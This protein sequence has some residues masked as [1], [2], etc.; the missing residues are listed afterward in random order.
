MK[1]LLV[2]MLLCLALSLNV[3]TTIALAAKDETKVSF[4]MTKDQTGFFIANHNN[5]Y[6]PGWLY[7]RFTILNAE[8]CTLTMKLQRMTLGGD[9]ITI[10][11]K[12]FTGNHFDYS[13]AD[14]IPGTKLRNHYLD[15]TKGSGCGNVSIEGYYGAEYEGTD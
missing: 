9:F 3:Q 4:I 1:K 11:E 5:P 10:S 2:C 6:D 12:E 8:G 14:Y 15:I 13:A 7:Y